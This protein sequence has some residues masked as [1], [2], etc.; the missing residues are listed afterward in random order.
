MRRVRP[1]A[2]GS[3]RP[4]SAWPCAVGLRDQS[5]TAATNGVLPGAPRPPCR[6]NARRRD[7]RRP[8]PFRP[9]TGPER[10]L[11]LAPDMCERLPEGHLAHHVGE[12]VDGPDM[13]AFRAPYEDG[14][15]RNGPYGDPDDGR[16]AAIRVCEGGVPV[17]GDWG[18][19]E[20]DRVFRMSGAR[21]LPSPRTLCGF[22]RRHLEGFKG[23]FAE[24]VRALRGMGW[25]TSE[26]PR[27]KR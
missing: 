20:E 15:R 16:S 24:V 2:C 9:S 3:P 6:P 27:W 14:G 7:G 12:L 19:P 10:P 17:A 1:R 22:R 18:S 23:L 8:S 5:E 26:S 25:R 11:P 4:G 13:T 21:N